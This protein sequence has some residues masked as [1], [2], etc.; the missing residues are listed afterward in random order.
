VRVEGTGHRDCG[1]VERFTDFQQAALGEVAV[2]DGVGRAGWYTGSAAD[3]QVVD[4]GG[5]LAHEADRVG[6][7]DVDAA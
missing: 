7:A 4:H 1:A 6:R 2:A 5:Q 3:T